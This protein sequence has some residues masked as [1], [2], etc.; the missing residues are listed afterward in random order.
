MK[1]VQMKLRR[2]EVPVRFLK[3]REG[4]LEP[5]QAHGMAVSLASGMD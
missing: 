4:P 1:S 3:D 5:S 2:A